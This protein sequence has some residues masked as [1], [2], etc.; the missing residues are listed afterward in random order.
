[1]PRRMPTPSRHRKLWKVRGMSDP[2]GPAVT[3]PYEYPGGIVLV[4]DMDQTLIHNEDNDI[5]NTIFNPRAIQFLQRAIK[6]PRLGAMLLLTNN[7]DHCFIIAVDYMLRQE[8]GSRRSKILN[9]FYIFDAIIDYDDTFR[10]PAEASCRLLDK[11]DKTLAQVNKMLERIGKSTADSDR[12]V[13]FFDD[14]ATHT[15][16]TQLSPPENFIQITPPFYIGQ[17]AGP[18]TT[19][20]SV[21]CAALGI[22]N[23]PGA[24][25]TNYESPLTP[26][27]G[28]ASAAERAA[29]NAA[30]AANAAQGGRR[31]R[32]RR[33]HGKHA[34]SRRAKKSSR[35]RI[36][37]KF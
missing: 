13:F 33:K 22:E 31:R 21:V 9:N 27:A 17:K 11:G 36:S 29:A 10:P 24:P 3:P 1:M 5:N 26:I 4:F 25:N 20:Y 6:S 8:V 18:D 14:L 16:S 7:R 23:I 2:N 34:K 12:R 28:N 35:R 19:D 15:I 32:T 37:P 30:N